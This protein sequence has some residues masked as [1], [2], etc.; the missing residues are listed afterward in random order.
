M[1]NQ[2]TTKPLTDE[3]CLMVLISAIDVGDRMRTVDEFGARKLS[4]SIDKQGLDN[5]ISIREIDGDQGRFSLVSGGH[6][7]RAHQMLGLEYIRADVR[8]MHASEAKRL[9]RDENFF[10]E[11]LTA[12][13]EALA[14]GSFIDEWEAE[15]G[16]LQWGGART[17][18]SKMQ[19]LHLENPFVEIGEKSGKSKRSVQDLVSIYRKLGP[20][21]LRN[22]RGT[23][24]E[25]NASQLKALS[26]LPPE[27][28][29]EIV[30]RLSDGRATTV[31]DAVKWDAN[32]PEPVKKS[33]SAKAFEKL[34]KAWDDA[35]KRTQNKFLKE[36]GATLT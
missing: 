10:R 32:T 4:K 27:D 20:E 6:R 11:G 16:P 28:H 14:A 25:D 18:E 36:I 3:R 35:D 7:I 34:Q 33:A 17:D 22:L 2:P 5:A 23:P 26:K 31:K 12:G 19:S 13:E 9:E 30:A 8:S 15:N 21:V 24:I 1:T 29:P